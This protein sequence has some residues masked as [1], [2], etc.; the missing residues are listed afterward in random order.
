MPPFAGN[1]RAMQSPAVTVYVP[2]RDYGHYLEQALESVLSQTFDDWE[3]I[4]IDDAS[5]DATAAVAQR[6]VT[7]EPAKVSVVRNE[8]PRGLAYNANRAIE[9]A[10]GRYIMRLDSDDWLDESALLVMSAYL[11]RH[12]DV[13]LVFPNYFYVDQNGNHLGVEFRKRV[14]T[15]AKL[16]DLP[17][18]GACTMVRKRV[19]KAIGGYNESHGAQDGYELWL[20]VLHRYS[21][22]NVATPLF[23]YRQHGSSLSTD[24]SRLLTAR[25]QIKRS[26]AQTPSSHVKPVV[27]AIVPAKNSYQNFENVVLEPVAGRPLIDWTLDA[28]LASGVCTHVAVTTDDPEVCAYAVGRGVHAFLRPPALSD[29]ERR[30]SEVLHDAVVRAESELN[31]H[32][33]I[34]VLLSMHTPLRSGHDVAQAVDTLLLFDADSVISVY[35][36]YDLHFV[37]SSHGLAPL[38]PGMI[39]R[40]RIERE[41]LYVHN[42]AVAACWREVLLP[43]DYFGRKVS[44]VVM[45]R[46]ASFQIKSSFDRW[47]V[48]MLLDQKFNKKER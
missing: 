20:K 4:I 47:L 44:H 3:L 23:F 15:E 29:P 1:I 25:S 39:R 17:A 19:I 45:P 21:V 24:E 12:P 16:L 40:L 11:D 38:N 33:D 36:D 2:C 46:E 37:H 5:Q 42:A 8:Q 14:G 32:P 30:L 22:A 43:T 48:G 28:A 26:L 35:E 34:V 9:M 6:F 10:R 7:R 13:A 31:I 18:H 27:L 41:G